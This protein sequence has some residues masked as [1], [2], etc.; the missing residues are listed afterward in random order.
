[1]YKKYKNNT[2]EV[3][4]IKH[5]LT[6]LNTLSV[7]KFLRPFFFIFLFKNVK[8]RFKQS[9]LC[10]KSSQKPTTLTQ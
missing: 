1:M 7:D 3:E 8:F 6:P 4:E 9:S 10:F 5:K 2:Y